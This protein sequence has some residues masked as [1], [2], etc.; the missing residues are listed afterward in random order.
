MSLEKACSLLQ[1]TY[2]ITNVASF[3]G[4]KFVIYFRAAT[5][6]GGAYCRVFF[7]CHIVPF[8]KNL[9]AVLMNVLLCSFEV[10]HVVLL[11]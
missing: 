4:R 2:R 10:G 7:I 8:K 9:Y 11:H 6:R 3:W 1:I 5:G